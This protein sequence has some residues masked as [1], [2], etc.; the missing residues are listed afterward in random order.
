MRMESGR[1][2]GDKG[3]FRTNLCKFDV[4]C[5]VGFLWANAGK[6][7]PVRLASLMPPTLVC[8]LKAES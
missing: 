3:F 5:D 1:A 2:R 6:A 8:N 7:A 4:D